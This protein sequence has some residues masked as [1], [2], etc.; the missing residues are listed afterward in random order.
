M[1]QKKTLPP[2]GELVFQRFGGPGNDGGDLA[3]REA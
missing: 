3:A 2:L 1:V